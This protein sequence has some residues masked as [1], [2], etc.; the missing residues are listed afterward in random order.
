MTLSSKDSSLYNNPTDLTLDYIRCYT[1]FPSLELTY[2]EEFLSFEPNFYEVYFKF[3][4]RVGESWDL[5]FKADLEGRLVM[6][7]AGQ[8]AHGI[9]VEIKG[10]R[11]N[12]SELV[13]M[14][15][16]T[17]RPDLNLRKYY[18]FLD[19]FGEQQRT[20]RIVVDATE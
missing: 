16:R 20:Q 1:V 9:S 19:D 13:G 7:D 2:E 10:N 14:H 17:W 8:S 11:L 6:L 12:L 3:P 18:Y 5:C 15:V 4:V